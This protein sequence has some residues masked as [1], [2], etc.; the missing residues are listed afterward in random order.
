MGVLSHIRCTRSSDPDALAAFAAAYTE[1]S[2]HSCDVAELDKDG[3]AVRFLKVDGELVGGYVVRWQPPFRYLGFIPEGAPLLQ[4][5]FPDDTIESTHNW[6]RRGIPKAARALW[7]LT[8]FWD[9]LTSRKKHFLG[10]TCERRIRDYHMSVLPNL[11]YEGPAA[12]NDEKFPEAWVYTGSLRTAL[13]RVPRAMWKKPGRRRDKAARA[14]ETAPCSQGQAVEGENLK[15][16]MGVV[17]R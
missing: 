1:V 10:G 12:L 3:Q 13:P 5:F 7:V 15:S 14:A 9:A 2:G 16:A 6:M 17:A 8:L 11:L 4:T